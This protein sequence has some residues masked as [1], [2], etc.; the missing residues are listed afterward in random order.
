MCDLFNID[1]PLS[2]EG[3]NTA[4]GVRVKVTF[5]CKKNKFLFMY[6]FFKK[7]ESDTEPFIMNSIYVSN[8]TYDHSDF[9]WEINEMIPFYKEM[10]MRS[11]HVGL[12]DDICKSYIN[13]T[14]IENYDLTNTLLHFMSENFSNKTNEDIC[15]DKDEDIRLTEKEKDT[16]QNI[17]NVSMV[18]KS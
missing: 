10:D 1:T 11:N 4:N 15:N 16:F 17:R 9:R 8:G 2:C 3:V 14:I 6:A 13:K 18:L 5:G 7:N 12:F